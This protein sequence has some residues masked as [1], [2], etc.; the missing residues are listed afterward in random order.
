MTLDKLLETLDFCQPIRKETK[1]GT[2]LLRKAQPTKE[3]WDTY[4]LDKPSYSKELKKIG[5]SINEFRGNWEVAWWSRPDLTFAPIPNF[6]LEMPEDIVTDIS[7][8]PALKFPDKLFQYQITSVQLGVRS[9]EKYNRALLGHGTGMG[10]TAIALAIARE[11]GKRVA[12]ICPKPIVTDWHRMAKYLG[13]ETY[14]VCGWEWV[15]TGKS[16]MGKW[17]SKEKKNF[18]WEIPKDTILVFD[19]VHRGKAYKTQ[20]AIIIADAVHQNISS[21]ALSATIADDPTKMWA[22]G[23]FLGL[24]KGQDYFPFLLRNDC[25]KTQWGMKFD[26]GLHVLSRLHKQIFP[27]RGNRLKPSDVGDE[28]PE[29]LIHARAFDMDSAKD[30]AAEYDKLLMRIEEL[31]MQE[32]FAANVLAEQTRARQAVELLKAPAVCSLAQDLI[33]EGNSV[34]I[35]V[36]YVETLKFMQNELKTKCTIQGGQNELLRRGNIDSFQNDKSRV[37]IGITQACREG[38]NLHDI[39]GRYPRIA[40]IMPTYSVFDLK[41]VLGRVH[42]AGGKSKSIQYLVYAAGVGIEEDICESLDMKLKRMDQLMD[43]E[44]DASISLTTLK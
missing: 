26:G 17:V 25:V 13:V 3:F 19:E 9:L 36:N 43:G 7:S 2:R 16:K 15:K 12:V 42:R 44:V 4:K 18:K 5:M 40:L 23:Q 10:K 37:I 34:F 33:E 39:N 22:I 38:L 28:F 30:I 41:Q 8:L 32:N 31:R 20:N 14:D 1:V 29:T 11:F 27:D 35:A 24:H 21:L 6:K